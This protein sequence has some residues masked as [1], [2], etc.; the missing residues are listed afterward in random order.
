MVD[1]PPGP[2]A[3]EVLNGDWEGVHMAARSSS[4]ELYVLDLCDD[5][6]GLRGLRRFAS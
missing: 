6:L 4:G 1:H 2:V 5:V 3:F